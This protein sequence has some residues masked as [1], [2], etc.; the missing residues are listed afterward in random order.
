MATAEIR[1]NRYEF[2]SIQSLHAEIACLPPTLIRSDRH[3][4]SWR[5]RHIKRWV[6]VVGS[7]FLALTVLPLGLII[8]LA[9]ALS[10]KGPVFYRERRVGR[11]GRLFKIWKFRS[12]CHN[13]ELKCSTNVDQDHGNSLQWRLYKHA[14]DPRVTRLGGFLRRWSLDEI[15]QLINVILGDMS[16]IGPRPVVEAEVPLYAHLQGF[17]LVATPGMS[18]LWQVSGRCNTSFEQ[19]ANLDAS[20][21]LYWSLKRDFIILLKTIPAVLRRVGAR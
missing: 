7:S 11:G 13:R 12:M 17:Y 6:D 3:V 8:S 15:P 14:C 9:V 18:G 4:R 2:A 10:S 21:V 19:R 5:Y 16:L 1:A 20:Y